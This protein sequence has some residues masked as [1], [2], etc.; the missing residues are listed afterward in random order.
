MKIIDFSDGKW[1]ILEIIIILIISFFALFALGEI[2]VNVLRQPMLTVVETL[3]QVFKILQNNDSKGIRNVNYNFSVDI[4]NVNPNVIFI[5]NDLI[6]QN[7]NF[8]VEQD[9]LDEEKKLA[10]ISS[11]QKSTIQNISLYQELFNKYVMYISGF[12]TV[13][14]NFPIYITINSDNDSKVKEF[15][16]SDI[17][18]LMQKLVKDSINQNGSNNFTH[19]S[20]QIPKLEINGIAKYS[21]DVGLLDKYFLI[22]PTSYYLFEGEIILICTRLVSNQNTCYSLDSINNEDVIILLDSDSNKSFQFIVKDTFIVDFPTAYIMATNPAKEN[23]LKIITSTENP[24]E[25]FVLIANM[26]QN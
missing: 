23:I 6:V 19:L 16:N 10:A 21:T 11:Q 15:V 7:K 8:S 20:I 12:P 17:L 14:Y 25:F 4:Q 22:V 26:Y 13:N 5:E 9:K 2:V 1:T 18:A 24:S 3:S